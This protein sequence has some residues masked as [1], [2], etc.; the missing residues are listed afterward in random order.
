[1]LSPTQIQEHTTYTHTRYSHIWNMY[2]GALE[3]GLLPNPASIPAN[4]LIPPS[5]D[6]HYTKTQYLGRFHAREWKVEINLAYYVVMQDKEQ[7]DDTIAH[8]LAHSLQ[9]KL[10]PQFKDWHGKEFR[11]IMAAI[12]YKG[13]ATVSTPYRTKDK[14]A[15]VAKAAKDIQLLSLL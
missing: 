10:C 8:E 11:Q 4:K 2:M 13:R 14:V 15:A 1:M 5:L 12:G 6:C 3:L 9:W 7:L